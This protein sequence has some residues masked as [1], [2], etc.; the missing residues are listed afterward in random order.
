M[1]RKILVTGATGFLG[2]HVV[3]QLVE[4][5][6]KVVAL[7]R[8]PDSEAAR[9]LPRGVKR[10]KGDILE[11]ESILR[12]ARGCQYLLHCAGKVSRNTDDALVM[13]R[14]NVL[15]LMTTLDAAKEAGVRRAVVAS[16][17]GVVAVSDDP[18]FV[19]TEEDETPLHLINRWPYY[20]TKL[21][22]EQ[23]ALKRNSTGF[24]VICVNPTL[25]LGPGD[26]YE[27]STGDVKMFLE[28]KIPAVPHGG[29]SYVD[30]RD[31]AAGMILALEK[32]T[33]GARYLLTAC[34]QELNNF[35]GRIGRI[36]N[37]SPPWL[38]LPDHP[39]ARALGNWFVEKGADLLGPDALPDPVS[40]DMSTHYWYADSTR[41]ETELG[42]T[43]RD[44]LDTILDTVDDLRTGGSVSGRRKSF[45]TNA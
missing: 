37:V 10:V 17:S 6:D 14:A 8:D 35:F 34:N 12:A 22:G 13:H 32:G 38:T 33:P 16:T 44:P 20:R 25:L 43:Y 15:G 39:I 4:G 31:A 40:F 30:V 9:A 29:I 11:D 5:G 18:D 24:E 28:G 3:S 36:A 7:C 23:E 45:L 21:Y 26:R 1:S 42:W 19:A 41:A 2:A 27:S